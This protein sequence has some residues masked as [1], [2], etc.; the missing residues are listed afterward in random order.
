MWLVRFE[1][2]TAVK[3][4]VVVVVLDCDAMGI[5]SKAPAFGETE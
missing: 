5:H 1:V 4:A 3:A 2:F